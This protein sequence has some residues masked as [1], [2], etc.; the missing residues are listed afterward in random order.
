MPTPEDE[1]TDDDEYMPSRSA[2]PSKRGSSYEEEK[3][4]QLRRSSGIAEKR[5]RDAS[6]EAE[7][8]KLEVEAR[9]EASGHNLVSG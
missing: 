1:K 8:E 9:G 3:P 6:A 4:S 7:L 2:L 5:A